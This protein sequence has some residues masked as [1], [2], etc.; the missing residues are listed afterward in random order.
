M[1]R[2]AARDLLARTGLAS[3]LLERL[4]P[5]ASPAQ[6]TTAELRSPSW[7]AERSRV[8]RRRWQVESDRTGARLWWYS[9]SYLLVGGPL[10][11]SLLGRYAVVPALN[12]PLWLDDFGNLDRVAPQRVVPREDLAAALTDLLEPAVRALAG[13]AGST[14]R[15]LWAVAGDAP[16][17]AVRE[18][19]RAGLDPAVVWP[20]V[21]DFH[22]RWRQVA[23]LPGLRTVDVSPAGVRQ[24]A[25]DAPLRPP[26]R[27]SALRNSCCLLLQVPGIQCCTTCPRQ[28]PAERER[29]WISSP[30]A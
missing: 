28:T 18:A 5:A 20:Q 22:R 17:M 16:T 2:W 1:N 13:V 21:V 8:A 19:L 10:L 3:P 25:E 12:D 30:E 11:T 9:A 24:V 15:S 7:L 23:P 4:T 14:P 29:R 26:A 27:R 6:W